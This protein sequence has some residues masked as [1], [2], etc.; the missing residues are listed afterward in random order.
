MASKIT[1]DPNGGAHRIVEWMYFDFKEAMKTDPDTVDISILN[2]AIS[3]DDIDTK[4]GDNLP[5]AAYDT[6]SV[7]NI[8]SLF[9]SLASGMD[10]S[11]KVDAWKAKLAVGDDEA[12]KEVQEEMLSLIHEPRSHTVQVL[13]LVFHGKDMPEEKTKTPQ[14]K[15]QKAKLG[16]FII[17]YFFCATL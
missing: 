15:V 8:V 9:E 12:K 13:Q 10:S 2:V 11:V 17:F 16:K 1:K 6:L 14:V 5:P 3:D 4:K 7:G